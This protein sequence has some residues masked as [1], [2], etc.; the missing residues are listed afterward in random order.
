MKAETSNRITEGVIWQQLLLFFF[1]ILFG[2]FF[3]QLYNAADA[4]IV[5]RFVG[6]EALSAVGGS[7]GML[8]NMIV[9]FFVG[10]SSGASVIISQYYGAKRP[11]MVGYAVHTSIAFSIA[12]GIIMMAAGIILAPWMLTA[13]GTP[14]DV[15]APSILY[16]RIYF[17]GMVGNLVYNTGAAI[18][19]AVGDSKRPLYFLIIS[20]LTNILL[21]VLFVIVF[22]LGVM[23]AACAT[24]LS[25][26][27]S[28][29]MVT[30]CLMRTADM[31]RL[32]WKQVRLDARM[33]RRI[34]RIGFPAGVQSVMYGLSNV[35]VQSGINSLGTD[36]VA[37]WAAYSKIDSVFWM[38]VNSFGI[39]VTTFVGQNYGA[40]KM[41]R[42]RGGVRSCMKMTLA[43]SALMSWLIYNWGIFGYELF[44]SDA[45]VI[46]IGIAMMQYLAPTYVTYVAIEV[47]SGSLR[48]VGDCWVPMMLCMIGICAIRVG[49]ILFAVPLKRDMYQIMFCYPLTWVVTT[50]LFVVYYLG[51]SRLKA[52]KQRIT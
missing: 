6:K 19:R 29:S 21:D 48:G 50:I 45:E 25:Q 33:L 20:C 7:A 13:M 14:E 18:L 43:A 9:G 31:H 5:G 39:A 52:T 36:S 30:V 42:V 40:G 32:I 1:P 8:T 37:A 4:M 49:W 23:G 34:I 10:L 35:I 28:A 22:R 24:I 41:D 3:Q 15:M 38:M 17:L 26:L 12:A 51:F 11:E 46:R 44:T 27:L 2:T 16:L 47:L